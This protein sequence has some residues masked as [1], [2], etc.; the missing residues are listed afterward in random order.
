MEAVI[1]R[2]AEATD[3]V[4]VRRGVS[5]RGLCHEPGPDGVPHITG[6]ATTDG[7]L[8]PADLV[9]DATGRRSKLPEWLAEVGAAPPHIESDDSG[10]VYFT[11]YFRGE[12][13]AQRGGNLTALGSISLLTLRSD[14][15]TWSLTVFTASADTALRPLRDPDRFE[16][17]IAA[18]PLQA[19]WLEG[20]RISD[21]EVMGGVLDKYRRYVV[22]GTAVAT[23]V[24]AVGDAWACTNPSAG[25]GI[26]VGLVHAKAL[27]DALRDVGCED[28]REFVHRFDDL[29]EERVTPFYRNQIANDRVRLAEMAAIRAGEQPP[30]P[31][32]RTAA[33]LAAMAKD[34]VVFRG[35]VETLTCLAFPQEVFARPGFQERVAPFVG[36]SPPPA[37]GPDREELLALLA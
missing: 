6:V 7:E 34:A 19:H 11:R 24:V 35:M 21:I 1:A 2:T 25:R 17:V 31:D 28:P 22:D 36:Q 5:V 33:V 20:E 37:P 15:G 23:G 12:Q 9:I 16:R 18:C 32:P 29:T 3:G 27:R 30:P 26:S 4:V 10:F 13:P 14:N 8:V